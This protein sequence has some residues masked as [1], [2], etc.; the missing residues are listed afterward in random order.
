MAVETVRVAAAD[1]EAP[2]RAQR[3]GRAGMVIA[4][5]PKSKSGGSQ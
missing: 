5:P 4:S 1:V 2:T 3:T